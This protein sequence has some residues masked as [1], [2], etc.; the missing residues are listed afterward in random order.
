MAADPL[1]APQRVELAGSFLGYGELSALFLELSTLR[2][3]H[4]D[5]MTAG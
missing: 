2:L 4:F 5:T 3:L 1:L